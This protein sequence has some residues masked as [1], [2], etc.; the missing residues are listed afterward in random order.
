M[1]E[2]RHGLAAL[3]ADLQLRIE[4]ELASVPP[5]PIVELVVLV[6]QQPLV[7]TAE[8]ARERGGIGA[9]RN[10]VNR[11]DAAAMMI[12]GVA[13]AEGGGHGGGDGAAGGRDALPIFPAADPTPVA[14][15]EVMDEPADV[16]R[17]HAG[18]RIDADEPR[19]APR[20][21]GEVERA[22][23]GA[24]GVAEELDGGIEM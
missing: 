2:I 17:R 23:D 8:L 9:E 16:V 4:E 11:P 12:R 6:G 3:P 15:L 22:R 14:G 1:K 21:K 24:L 20:A 5:E 18:V 19:T 7:P 13:D 10:V